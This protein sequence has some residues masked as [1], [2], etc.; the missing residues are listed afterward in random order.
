MVIL[1]DI[2]AASFAAHRYAFIVLENTPI[3]P[4]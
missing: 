1:P 3:K 4:G 2:M